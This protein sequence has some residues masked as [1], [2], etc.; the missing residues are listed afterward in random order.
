MPRDFTPRCFKKEAVDQRENT[1]AILDAQFLREKKNQ[2]Q[3]Q[4]NNNKTEII[5]EQDGDYIP[6]NFQNGRK[7]TFTTMLLHANTA[8]LTQL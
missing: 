3:N 5:N 8:L 7:Y 4:N 6:V 2:P 1:L